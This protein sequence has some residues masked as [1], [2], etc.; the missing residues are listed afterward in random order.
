L[1]AAVSGSR[2]PPTVL[3]RAATFSISTRSSSGIS[4][5]AAEAMAAKACREEEG[6]RGMRARPSV[7]GGA[8]LVPE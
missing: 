8:R 7:R 1:D 6:R 5:L 3:V 2:M 4:F